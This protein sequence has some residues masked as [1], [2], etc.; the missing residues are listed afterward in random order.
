[1][2]TIGAYA[3][4][5]AV[6]H[7]VLV[8][9]CYVLI[10]T[11]R[12]FQ[13]LRASVLCIGFEQPRYTLAVLCIL[14]HMTV[15]ACMHITCCICTYMYLCVYSLMRYTPR[16]DPKMQSLLP[17]SSAPFDVHTCFPLLCR[18]CSPLLTYM[19]HTS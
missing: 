15:C 10:Y 17:H 19:L 7:S 16:G 5:R 18:I 9:V 6:L 12:V 1:M 14:V 2:I 11:S 13:T 4:V 8:C 3:L